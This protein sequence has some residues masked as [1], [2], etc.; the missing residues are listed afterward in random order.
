VYHD[1]EALELS[2]SFFT[3][4]AAKSAPYRCSPEQRAAY[5]VN[6]GAAVTRKYCDYDNYVYYMATDVA[7][8][9][10][11]RSCATCTHVLVTN[12]DNGYHPEFFA[13]ALKQNCDVVSTDFAHEKGFLSVDWSVGSIDLGGVLMTTKVVSA[14]KGYI[15]SLPDPLEPHDIHDGDYWLIRRAID[16]GFSKAVVHKLLYYHQ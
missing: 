14:V 6:K 10:V 4:A 7:L 15:A 8:Q 2:Q 9:D 5:L 16:Q 11:I 13:E 3:G 1:V 12:S